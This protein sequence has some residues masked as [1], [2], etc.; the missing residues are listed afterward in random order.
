MGG[1]QQHVRAL[2]ILK[3]EQVR[4]VLRPAAGGLVRFAREEGREV[5]LL[6][7]AGIHLFTDDVLDLGEHAQAEREPRVDSGGGAADVAGADEEAMGGNLGIGR[8]FAQR[9]EKER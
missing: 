4:A 9:A 5:D 1:G 8:V 2:A 6:S 7:A 3:T